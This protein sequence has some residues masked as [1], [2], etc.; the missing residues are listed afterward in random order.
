MTIARHRRDWED[1]GKIDPLWA[2]LSDPARQFGRWDEEEFFRTGEVEIDELVARVN[3]LQPEL[4]KR[5]ALDFGCGVGRL[6]RALARHFD[7]VTGIDISEPMIEQARRLNEKIPRCE[8]ILSTQEDLSRYGSEQFDLI[9]TCKVLQH[10]PDARHILKYVSE[11]VRVLTSDGMAVFQVP[12]KIPLR[13][14]L[15]WRRWAY[16]LLRFLGF[17]EKYL[18]NR[19]KLNPIKM[20]TVPAKAVTRAIEHAGGHTLKIIA[21]DDAGPRVES[22]MFFVVK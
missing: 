14:R 2:V 11:F 5:T 20:T 17:S 13:Y 9:Y 22:L 16:L 19:L 7:H 8:F 15:N 3:S 4:P 6:T 1:L 10:Q 18:Y 21:T 12:T